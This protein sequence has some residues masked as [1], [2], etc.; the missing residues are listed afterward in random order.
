MTELLTRCFT[1]QVEKLTS[2]QQSGN[3]SDFL[4]RKTTYLLILSILV[5]STLAAISPEGSGFVN[6]NLNHLKLFSFAP[7]DT[8]ELKFPIPPQSPSPTEPT[9]SSPLYLSEPS[10]ITREVEY[11]P[12][13]NEYILREK[14]GKIP[15]RPPSTLT[16]Q[17][18]MKWDE[19]RSL[20]NY[21]AERAKASGQ[22][23]TGT[24]I[25]PQVHIGGEVFE[26]IFGSGTIDIRPQGS[27]ELTFGVLANRRE[28]P[29]LSVRQQ[30]VVNFDFQ[31]RIQMSVLAK[32]GDKIEFQTNYNTEATFEFENKL[33]LKYE[34][35][36]DEIIQLIEAGNVTLPLNSTLITGSQALFGIKTKLKFG[37]T[38]I[39]AIY[40]EQE[41]ETKSITV[42]GGAQ[43]NR[44]TVQCDQYEENKHFLLAQYFRETYDTALSELP[45]IR[46]NVN[47]TKIEVWVTNIGAAVSN[48]RNIIALQD[49]GESQPYNPV[50]TGKPF[51]FP[52][53]YRSNNLMELLLQYEAD[54]RDINKVSDVLSKPPFGFEFGI[55]AVKV[56]S[57]RKLNPNEY[58]FNPKLGF[59]SLNTSLNPD[60]I[61]AVAFQYNVIGDT[62]IYQVGE[63]SDQGIDSPKNLIVKL[64]RSNSLSTRVP[65]WNLMMKNVYH[66]GAYQVQSKDFIL[67]IFYSGNENAVPTSYLT[68]AGAISGIPLLR[69]LNFDNLD[70]QLNPPYDGIFDFIDNAATQGGTIQASNGRVY[71]TVLE[72]FGSY[73]RKKIGNDDIA[74]R[75]A[76]DSLYTLTKSGAQQYPEKNKFFLEGFYKSSAGSEISLNALNVPQGSVKVT[77]GGVPLVENVDYTVDYTMGRVRIINE[78]VLNSGTPIN[79]TLE[80]QNFFTVQ[81]KRLM[82]TH[83]DYRISDNFNIG[84]TILNLTERPLTRKVNYGMDPISNTIWGMDVSYQ[85]Q[86]R[87]ITRIVDKL[88]F[89]SAKEDS[90][91]NIDGEFA[92]F[93][94]GHAKVIG[95]T[96][97]SYIDDFEAA[98]STIDLKNMAFWHLA[99]TPQKQETADMFPEGAKGT[100]LAYGFNRALLAWYIIDPLFYDETGN[101]RPPNISLNELSDHQVRQVLETEVFPNKD[102]PNGIPTNI[103]ILNLAFYPNER[104]PYNYDVEG[105]PGISAGINPDGTLRAP[106]TRWG[107]IM[108]RI[109]STNFE[110][111]NVEYIEFWMMDPFV[112]DADNSGELYFNLGDISE[113]ILRDGR[114]SFEHGLPPTEVVEN[115]DTTIWGRVP[116]L[117][118]LVDNFSNIAGSRQYQDVGYDGLRDV[119]E[120]SFFNQK[121]LSK[122]AGLYGENSD[123][124]IRAVLDPSSDNYHYFR[125]TDYDQ[126]PVY[127]SILN[128]YK[129]FNG[130]DGNSPTQD[131]NPEAYPTAATNI[132]N[133]EDIN[134]D[135][136]LSENE[137]YFQYKVVLD[138]AAMNVGQNFITDVYTARGIRLPNGQVGEVKWYQFKIPI[139]QPEKIVGGIQD[140][141]SIRFLRMFMKGFR[142]PIVL[143]FATLE[144]V[145]G[146]WR[147]YQ[148]DLLSPGEYIPNDQQNET[149]FDILSVNIEEN[150]KR[151]PIPYVIPPG[152]EREINLGTTNLQKLNEQSMVLRVCNLMDGDARGAY[153]TTD[154]DFRDY[155]F[156]EMFV[157]AE[158]LIEDQELKDG[159]LT[160]FIRFGADLTQNFYEYEIPLKFTPW[161]TSH[162]DPEAIWPVENRFKVDLKRLVEFKMER[163]RLMRELG[164][165]ITASM[166]YYTWD[167]P[168]RVTILG[169]PNLSSVRAIM[170]GV[171]NPKQTSLTGNDDGLPKCAEIW[172][173]ELRLTDFNN[174]GGFAATGRIRS[175]LAD[176]GNMTLA[177]LYSTPGFGSIEKKTSE[178]AKE[179]VKNWDFS[180]NIELGKFF[181]EKAGLRIPMH[182]DYS[183]SRTDPKYNLLDPDVLL[184]EDLRDRETRRERDSLLR[185]NEDFVM[186]KNLNFINMRKTK[187]GAT[188]KSNFYDIEN[189]GL[190]YS[191]SE[192]FARNVDYEYDHQ[193]KYL[194]GIGYNFTNLPKNYK[195][196]SRIKA[197]NPKP[198]AFLRDFNFYL[199]PKIVSVRTDMN[200]EYN[201]RL[202][203]NKSQYQVII[204]P[205]YLKKWDWTRNYTL[206]WDFTTSLRL[207]Y[208]ADVGSYIN[209]LPGSLEK[210][211]PDYEIKKER[212]RSELLN[213]GTK[214]LFMQN[215]GLNYNIPI[216]KFPLLDWTSATARYQANYRWQASPVSL[217][218]RF[219]NQIENSRTIQLNANLSFDRIYEKIPGLKKLNQPTGPGRPGAMPRPGM[220]QPPPTQQQDTARKDRPQYFKI[221]G[222]TFLRILTSFK[223]ASL[224][225][226]QGSG[227]LLPGFVP[228]AGIIGNDWTKNAPGIGFILGSQQ[229]IR[230]KAVANN[231]LTTDTLLNTAYLSKFNEQINFR[232]NIEP[233]PDF[234]IEL[235]ADRTYGINYQE[236]FKADANGRFSSYSPQEQG[237]FSMS[238]LTWNT[239]WVKDNERDQNANFE[240]MK[241]NRREIAFRLARNNPNWNGNVVDSTGFPEGY[242]PSQQ[243]VLMYSFLSAYMGKDPSTFRLEAMPRI[244][245][246]NWRLTYNGLSRLQPFSK[247]LRNF[248]LTHG[249]RSSYSIGS[250]QSNL[251]YREFNGAPLALD[252]SNNF[253]YQYLI[254]QV[255]IVEQFTPLVSLDMTW[256][257]NLMSKFEIKKT[258]NLSLS[259][260]N[261]QLT[262]VTSNEYVVGLGYRF[263][264]VSFGIRTSTPGVPGSRRTV[265]SDLNVR[266]DFSIKNN[267][268]VLRRIDEDVNQVSSGQRAST[269]NLSAEYTINQ[270]LNLKLFFD[271]TTNNPFVSSQYRTSTTH[272]GITLRFTLAQ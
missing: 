112:K 117:Q 178:R 86:S 153:K 46:S 173:N 119:D 210:N 189:F 229:D 71:F 73:L 96:G 17:E 20:R 22:P 6:K 266:A 195:P 41:S 201:K 149:T 125:G 258:R 131:I 271:K 107:G 218:Q 4:A 63:F 242:G 61:L 3:G 206:N 172:V 103:P 216:N 133:A 220:P 194:A 154:F 38:M 203:R 88:P 94:P 7:A 161:Y 188:T 184:K 246:L 140:F 267:K 14:V 108:R 60:Q 222:N 80:S 26:R 234:R 158:K 228:V 28:D 79:I 191:Y 12:E 123:A 254:A 223:R 34:G 16:L 132:P 238:V 179:F 2:F 245:Q 200:R 198:L 241:E 101:L 74:D 192:I 139:R 49:L 147:R 144:L 52:D 37:R 135:N 113:D 227:I 53:N 157:H 164:S 142:K 232:G 77:A 217:Q 268:T 249:Y 130:P 36:E 166:P 127:S 159:D 171:R 243:E 244:P 110:A 111:T 214:N 259:F 225:Y 100:G 118:A 235:S 175:D 9:P 25:I 57:A 190:T 208:K 105:E 64:I 176:L 167:G 124:F 84:G 44:F 54:V 97:T 82:G 48:N 56:E 260:V 169:S 231:W 93:I 247:Y 250:F 160:V 182:F 213:L 205:T 143:R 226:S 19:E 138:P 264:E 181:P 196:F 99:S 70:P 115:V 239:A 165:G 55:D 170:I 122:I 204:E 212:I 87:L 98:K 141:Q 263:K 261:N 18:Y 186:R 35:K 21:W 66:I 1:D 248:T 197:F 32:I 251:L 67:N 155:G 183:E 33:N 59:I 78:G 45:V 215:L 81:T 85:T 270:R 240:R 24:G 29:T 168:N 50:I 150:G 95:R 40:S 221:A 23:R 252:N 43:T 134:R 237:N 121:Y 102:V 224:A 148:Y 120:Q 116:K 193:K 177:G 269:I 162:N 257:N 91:I 90:K 163:N 156:L 10:N 126:N 202:L 13:N 76:Y 89:I 185:L 11:D 31:Q 151:I 72:P 47:I 236:Y 211:D 39:T 272:G 187:V 128:R 137:R 58:T 180:T 27:A 219:G 253:I 262:E 265:K 69:V 42:Q 136:T 62:T 199:M 104:G 75:F 30:N 15:L 51:I 146:D 5:L 233:F 174:Q 114:K 209:E 230:P 109:E 255:G 83:I 65:I 68:D 207:D 152:I 92:H 106:E 8:N 129:R 256:V 145:R